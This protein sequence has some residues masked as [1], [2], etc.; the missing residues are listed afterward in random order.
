[1]SRKINIPEHIIGLTDEE[2][3]ASRKSL[4]RTTSQTNAQMVVS[5][6]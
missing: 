2:V 4:V 1:M 5:S 3:K 6:F